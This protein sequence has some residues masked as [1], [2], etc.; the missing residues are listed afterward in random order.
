MS[1]FDDL[2]VWLENESKKSSA[3]KILF[4]KIDLLN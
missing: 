1:E 4:S 3:K 2:I